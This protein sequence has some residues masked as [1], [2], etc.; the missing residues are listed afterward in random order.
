MLTLVKIKLDTVDFSAKNSTI[1][2]L[3]KSQNTCSFLTSKYSF[4]SEKTQK[5]TSKDKTSNAL[6]MVRISEKSFSKK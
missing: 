1:K 2:Q 3:F 5:L 4:K 6:H